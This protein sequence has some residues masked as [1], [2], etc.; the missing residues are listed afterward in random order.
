MCIR[1]SVYR[2]ME[3]LDKAAADYAKVIEIAPK[4]A[5]GWRNRAL[6]KLMKDDFKGGIADYDEALKYD[7]RDAYSWNNRAIAK[8]ESGDKDGAIAD[9]KKALEINPQLPTARKA[10]SEMGAAP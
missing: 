6:I 9:F 5:R 3:Q 1:D 4:D 8:R 2:S 7:A 10:L